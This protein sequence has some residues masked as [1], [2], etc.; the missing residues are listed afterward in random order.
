VCQKYSSVTRTERGIGRLRFAGLGAF[1]PGRISSP[2][3]STGPMNTFLGDVQ[4][5]IRSWGNGLWFVGF[6]LILSCANAA[7]YSNRHTAFLGAAIELFLV[8]F[9][10]TQRIWYLRSLRNERF[11]GREV[12]SLS[13]SFFGQFLRLGLLCSIPIVL[14]LI[15][16][17]V[18]EDAHRH[19]HAAT[20]TPVALR[21]VFIGLT[22]LLDFALTFVVP[23]LAFS[24]T[25]AVDALRSGIRMIGQLWPRCAWYVLAPGLTLSFGS[26]LVSSHALGGWARPILIVFGAMAA[27]LFRG[28]V[29]PFY[30]RLHPEVGRD[31]SA[32]N[33]PIKD[34]PI[35]NWDLQCRK[36]TAL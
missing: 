19:G 20:T 21:L 29:V 31:G 32:G 33:R 16:W 30:L 1:P 23:T 13:W 28:A 18:V 12:W 5:A 8:G 35:P 7:A 9:S 27:F 26:L 25:S 34:L 6:V 36:V 24:T 22:L 4:W 10:G 2:V 11:E 17:I 3:S 14:P 15:I